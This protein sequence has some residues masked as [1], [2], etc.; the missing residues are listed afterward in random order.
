[1]SEGRRTP[2]LLFR[3]ICLSF[4]ALLL[5]M[6]LWQQIR[7]TSCEKE[8]ESLQQSVSVERDRQVQLELRLSTQ[9][10]LDELESYAVQVLGMQHPAPDQIVYL[11]KV[12]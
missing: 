3:I 1:M 9:L 5:V 4:S 12:G 11:D 10:T 8:I 7:L 6:S 2:A